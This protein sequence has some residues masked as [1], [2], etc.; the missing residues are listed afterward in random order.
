MR[1]KPILAAL[2]AGGLSCT[3]TA[4]LWAAPSAAY[5]DDGMAQKN[6]DNK[7]A[8]KIRRALVE[9]KALSTYAHNVKI[10][11]DHGQVILRG[12][13]RSEAEERAVV[14]KARV[15]AGAGNVSSE[16]TIQPGNNTR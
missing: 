13:V 7:I 8:S 9:D 6:V 1:L 11:V 3:T 15:I 14:E 4:L 5:A 2:I 12:P 10:L 16:L